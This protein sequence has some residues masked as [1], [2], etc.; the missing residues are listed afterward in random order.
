MTVPVNADLRLLWDE[1]Y[2][3]DAPVRLRQPS[4]VGD[5]M[6]ALGLMVAGLSLAAGSLTI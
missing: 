2:G 5:Y 6:I 3:S 1:R 4:H